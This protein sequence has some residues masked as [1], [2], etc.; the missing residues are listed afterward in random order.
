MVYL[1]K[2]YETFITQYPHGLTTL[3]IKTF[4][5]HICPLGHRRNYSFILAR[6]KISAAAGAEDRH[7]QIHVPNLQVGCSVFLSLY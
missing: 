2:I 6:R 3:I 5:V 1:F 7:I 4:D